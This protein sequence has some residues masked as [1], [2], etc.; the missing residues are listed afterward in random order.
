MWDEMPFKRD[1]FKIYS[2]MAAG[3]ENRTN[4]LEFILAAGMKG[5]TKEPSNEASLPLFL[6]Y[7]V[8]QYSMALA[9]G[10]LR[11]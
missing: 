3:G 8:V 9:P 5:T 11:Q 10:W 6:R 4:F 2:F 7:F 1:N